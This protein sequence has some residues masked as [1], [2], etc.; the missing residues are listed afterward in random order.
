MNNSKAPSNRQLSVASEIQSIVSN[1]FATKSIYHPELEDVILSFPIVK[2]T[3]D[4]KMATI[5]ASCLN[6]NDIKQY[7]TIINDITPNIRKIIASKLKLRYT[8]DIRFMADNITEK[9][10]KM[11]KKLSAIAETI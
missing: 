3:P 8:P 11:A 1:I 9:E 5:Y 4:L 2:I 10:I 7:I 6:Q